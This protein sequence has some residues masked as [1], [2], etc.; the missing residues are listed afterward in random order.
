M[1]VASG[2]ARRSGRAGAGAACLDHAGSWWRSNRRRVRSHLLSTS[3][4]RSRA[5]REIGDPQVLRGDAV[6][7]I[8]DDERDVGALRRA[9][10][11]QD[12]VV[13]DGLG[14][15]GGAADAGRVHHHERAPVDRERRCR[16]RHAWYPTSETITR[17]PPRKRV[18]QRGLAD[19]RAADH[20][21]AH[22]SSSSSGSASSSG[23]SAT[24]RSSRSPAPS[25]CAADTG[26]GSPSPSRWK[27]GRAQVR[28]GRSCS[29]RRSPDVAAPQQVGELLVAGPHP[30]RASTTKT[31]TSASASAARA[32][33]WIERRAGG[34]VEVDA[35]GV[36]QREAAPF[37]SVASSLRSRVM[38]GARRR[39]PR[40]IC[41][42]R[43]TSEDLP[44]FG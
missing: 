25:P 11:A 14:D 9:L 15:L 7:G 12:R 44:T 31:A 26:L 40:A 42:S 22:E 34:L 21:E 17:S 27:S 6:R 3:A 37:H 24:T 16:S 30:A 29:R 19:V 23:S 5:H 36:D 35:A 39:P 8:A 28:G 2:L 38:P 32:W 33:S 10:R 41:V 18:D 1:D 43:L 20:R 13:L 4:S